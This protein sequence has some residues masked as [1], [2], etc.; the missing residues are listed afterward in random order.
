MCCFGPDLIADPAWNLLLDLA[1]ARIEGRRICVT[2]ACIASGV[3]PTTALRWI[4]EMVK[5]GVLVREA[6]EQDG[7]RAWVRISDSAF[8]TLADALYVREARAA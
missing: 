2:S 3:A 1:L 7:R 4:G 5:R 6:D 8:N